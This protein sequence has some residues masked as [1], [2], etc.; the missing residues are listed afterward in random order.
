MKLVSKSE[1]MLNLYSMSNQQ[2]L[3]VSSGTTMENL[4]NITSDTEFQM[5]PKQ[6]LIE[7]YY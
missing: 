7:P 1:M 2:K 5:I 3:A 4:L 6:V